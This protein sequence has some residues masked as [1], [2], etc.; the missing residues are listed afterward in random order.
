MLGVPL[1]GIDPELS[2]L[3]TKSGSRRI[4]RDAGVQLLDGAEDL[5]SVEEVEEEVQQLRARNPSA[6]SVVIKL[7]N[8]FS[9][10]GNAI[11]DLATLASPIDRS[12]TTFCAESES[13][14]SYAAKIE[15]EGAVIEEL[16]RH[17]A[18]TSP[19]VQMRIFPTGEVEVL[20]THDQILGGP[21]D[22]V[23]LGCRFPARP[24]YR[25]QIRDAAVKVASVLAEH[26]V[27]GPFGIDFVIVPG[28]GEPTVFLSE[29][30]LRMGGTTHPMIMAQH[31]T[32]GRY[33]PVTDELIAG[34]RAVHYFASDNIKSPAYVGMSPQAAIDAV[35]RAGLSFDPLT[36]SGATLHLLGA[37]PAYGKL[38]ALCIADSPDRAHDLYDSVIGAL[39]AAAGD[40]R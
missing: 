16:V 35:D 10:Q 33:D 20:S 23:Y 19:S 38:G 30:N 14:S 24:D 26:G 8:G 25:T 22:Q 27:I 17:E 4:A 40:A 28:E 32:R 6:R 37:V 36:N 31:L 18:A 3:G 12:P 34:G 7:N 13:W 39:D 21:D 5:T 29:I 2:R 9:G 11:V 1:Y 15:A